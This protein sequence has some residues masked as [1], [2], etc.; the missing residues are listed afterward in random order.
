[1]YSRLAG[2]V[3]LATGAGKSNPFFLPLLPLSNAHTSAC[4]RVHVKVFAKAS[5]D[6][7]FAREGTRPAPSRS[8]GIEFASL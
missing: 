4:P 5:S 2:V 7:G 3:G 6:H 8:N 1:V